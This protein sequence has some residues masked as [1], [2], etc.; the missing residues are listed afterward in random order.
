MTARLTK[1]LFFPAFSLSAVLAN[2]A[3]KKHLCDLAEFRIRKSALALFETIE[4]S[5]GRRTKP[6]WKASHSSFLLSDQCPSVR[7]SRRLLD[8]LFVISLSAATTSRMAVKMSFATDSLFLP[9]FVPTALRSHFQ[10][11]IH[12]KFSF[13]RATL[14]PPVQD[15]RETQSFAERWS[16]PWRAQ[17]QT[18][19]DRLRRHRPK[20]ILGPWAGSRYISSPITNRR[21][22]GDRL[23][24]PC[25]KKMVWQKPL[26]RPGG[27]HLLP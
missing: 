17:K 4:L 23:T 14:K 5:A 18:Q 6:M 25:P 20:G 21:S 22:N 27:H 3:L 8:V 7:R 15:G 13:Q 19:G 1:T 9:C 11:Q 26:C 24:F 2:D 10:S 12:N 16:P